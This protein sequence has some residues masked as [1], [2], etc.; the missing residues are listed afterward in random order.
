MI[1]LRPKESCPSFANFKRKS[2][3]ELLELLTKALKNQI[4]ALEKA[5]KYDP[6]LVAQLRKELAIADKTL[7]I[8]RSRNMI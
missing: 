8:Q 6:A 2:V 5:E 3:P 7:E 1:D 4:E